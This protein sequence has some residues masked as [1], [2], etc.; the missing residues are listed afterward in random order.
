MYPTRR[1]FS[2]TVSHQYNTFCF[3]FSK[4][5]PHIYTIPIHHNGIICDTRQ[6]LLGCCVWGIQAIYTGTF[7]V[8]HTCWS[9]IRLVRTGLYSS[10]SPVV[11]ATSIILISKK[12]QNGDIR[13][14]LSRSSLKMAVKWVVVTKSI[15]AVDIVHML[16]V[17]IRDAQS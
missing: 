5:F 8:P 13:Y 10:R 6:R 12:I 15:W 1:Q 4:N 3:L 9:C 2:R 7:L 16:Q 17:R 14:V 11:T